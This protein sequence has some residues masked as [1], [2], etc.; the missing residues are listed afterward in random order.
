MVLVH[1]EKNECNKLYAEL[2]KT[3]PTIRIFKPGN[4][5]SEEFSFENK[6]TCKVFKNLTNNLRFSVN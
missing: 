2:Q 3:F 6:K 4:G 1:G 5:K